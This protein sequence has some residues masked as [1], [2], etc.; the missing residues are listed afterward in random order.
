MDTINETANKPQENTGLSYREV[1][2]IQHYAKLK[3][4][5]NEELPF[6]HLEEYEI[7]PEILFPTIT[8]PAVSIKYKEFT[9]NMAS[10][11]LFDGIHNVVPSINRKKKRLAVLMRK[12]ECASSVVWSRINKNGVLK[13]RTNTSLEFVESIYELMGWERNL[14]YKAT[15]RIANSAEGLI[16]VFD[17]ND[18]A[19]YDALPEE[20]VDPA[21]GEVKKHIKVYYPEKYRGHVGNYYNDYV[22]REQV[23]MFE[24]LEDYQDKKEISDSAA[25]VPPAT[26]IG[27]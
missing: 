25:Q 8:K 18:A 16:L 5:S 9:F 12:E 7:P 17:L 2:L 6:E 13:N 19:K 1:E 4:E 27:G 24:S 3:L 10:V 14:R 11:R 20:Y 26:T 23:S 21:T 22:A 15:G